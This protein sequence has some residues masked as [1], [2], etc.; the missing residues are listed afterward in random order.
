VGVLMQRK[1]LGLCTQTCGPITSHGGAKYFLTFINE[2][3][4]KTF[5]NT[6]KTKFGV[7]NK[8]KVFKFLIKKTHVIRNKIKAIKCDGKREYTS[9]N[10]NTLCKEDGIMKQTPFH[11]HYNI[12]M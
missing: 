8:L 10:F 7:L 4:G 12:M 1:F 3:I 2:F 11:T 6:M 9:K 5:L